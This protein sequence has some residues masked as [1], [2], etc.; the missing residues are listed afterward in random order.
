MLDKKKESMLIEVKEALGSFTESQKNVFHRALQGESLFITGGPGTGKSFLTNVLIKR[1][2]SQDK[3]VLVMA[4]TGIAAVHI[5]GTT[6]H[7]GL[8]LKKGEVILAVRRGL[9]IR[10]KKC[11]LLDG[12]D[13]VFIDEISMARRDL[14]ELIVKCIR[15]SE[16]RTGK[17]IQV[18]MVGDFFQLPPVI[19]QESR[20]LM[21]RYYDAPVGRG[22]AF[23]AKEW[24][25]LRLTAV[26][27][28]ETVRQKDPEFVE[29]LNQLRVGNKECIEYFNSLAGEDPNLP[30]LVGTN[31]KADSINSEKIMELGK[32]YDCPPKEYLMEVESDVKDSDM[33]VPKKLSLYP[34][35]RVMLVVNDPV[36]RYQNGSCG[37]VTGF[38]SNGTTPYVNV[39]LDGAKYDIKIEPYTWKVTKAFVDDTGKLEQEECGSYTQLPMKL[40]YAISIHKSQ[41][42][43]FDAVNIDTDCWEAAQLYVAISR[44]RTPAGVHLM[45][46]IKPSAVIVDQ[47]VIDFYRQINGE[48]TEV[49][50][51][52]IEDETEEL[53]EDVVMT[54]LPVKKD[55][56]EPKRRSAGR[57][58]PFAEGT[59]RIRVGA[60][61]ADYIQEICKKQATEGGKIRWLPDEL[62]ICLSDA[63]E[64]NIDFST[65][66]FM[67]VPLE[68]EGLVR[69]E[70][71]NYEK[72]RF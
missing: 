56:S 9:E 68:L 66:T 12:A 20:E 22:Y 49:D 63:L 13:V 35:A 23:Q 52:N 15:S 51:V 41:G 18:I 42:A 62:D 47:S 43:T 59:K 61:S 8:G 64:S 32:K 7:R 50:T 57:P 46:K 16:K 30:Y 28:K 25:E 31:L 37:I 24:K 10:A 67:A 40:A 54:R 34:G 45:Q 39:R 53:K 19:K 29:A 36:G 1:F 60:D 27:L 17:H 44:V 69:R 11:P 72:R 4:S 2:L 6:I 5:G 3:S 26:E 33:V 58:T 14:F 48:T 38:G 65:V 21:E 55:A 71:K 70:I